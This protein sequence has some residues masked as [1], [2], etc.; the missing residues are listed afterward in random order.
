V[1]P[2]LVQSDFGYHI[3]DPVEKKPGRQLTLDEVRADLKPM[4]LHQKVEAIIDAEIHKLR[5]TAT[6][7]TY[8]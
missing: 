7:K 4:V 3:V 8:I 5:K 6:I 1:I 2:K